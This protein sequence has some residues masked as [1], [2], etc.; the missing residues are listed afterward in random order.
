MPAHLPHAPRD[1]IKPGLRSI[2]LF[3]PVVQ[4]LIDRYYFL[5]TFL[6]DVPL[7]AVRYYFHAY[8]GTLLVF[9]YVYFKVTA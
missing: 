5:F 4:L 6:F 9:I 3:P 8:L 1:Q 2:I 7:T